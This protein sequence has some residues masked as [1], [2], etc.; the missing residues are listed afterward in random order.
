MSASASNASS[1]RAVC[2]G[3]GKPDQACQKWHEAKKPSDID[4]CWSC[5]QSLADE[6]ELR[7]HMDTCAGM[8]KDVAVVASYKTNEAREFVAMVL[9]AWDMSDPDKRAV[10]AAHRMGNET[11]ATSAGRSTVTEVIL[12]VFEG[13]VART[14]QSATGAPAS[15]ASGTAGT[16]TMTPDDLAKIVQALRVQPYTT[17]TELDRMLALRVKPFAPPRMPCA[18]ALM[19]W[20]GMVESLL[21]EANVTT[22]RIRCMCV[23]SALPAS[24]LGRVPVQVHEDWAGLRDAVIDA[25]CPLEFAS[26]A[27]FLRYVAALDIRKLPMLEQIVRV[28]EDLDALRALRPGIVVS[29]AQ[30]IESVLLPRLPISSQE[31]VSILLTVERASVPASDF[32]LADFR[33]ACRKAESVL[34]TST[35]SSVNYVSELE[36]RESANPDVQHACYAIESRAV[37]LQRAPPRGLAISGPDMRAKRGQPRSFECYDCGDQAGHP[38]YLC[39]HKWCHRCAVSNPQQAHGHHPAGCPSRWCSECRS[40]GHASSVC[41]DVQR[42]RAESTRPGPFR[43]P[44]QAYRQQQQQR[45]LA[46]RQSSPFQGNGTGPGRGASN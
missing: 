26:S 38:Y 17:K 12:H 8:R 34:T 21:A 31:K 13:H 15:S 25:C 3:C 27:S 11:G 41:E 44:W 14:Q 5:G 18:G 24:I 33:D 43:E 46:Q 37:Q 42:R 40:Y 6:V 1:P 7:A 2:K 28:Q 10:L 32:T 19:Q 39:P 4:K 30:L 23:R 29:E 22:D 36:D 20:L 35:S 9:D 45:V 16:T